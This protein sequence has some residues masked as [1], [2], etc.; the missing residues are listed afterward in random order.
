MAFMVNAAMRCLTEIGCGSQR[1]A[2]SLNLFASNAAAIA[3][4]S[5]A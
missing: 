4:F 3:V 1:A 2:A 5:L